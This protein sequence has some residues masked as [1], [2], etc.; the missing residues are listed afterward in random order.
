MQFSRQLNELSSQS[1]CAGLWP[2][3]LTWYAIHTRSKCEKKVATQLD[4]KQINCFLPAV[5][6]M[7]FWS[8]RQKVIERPLFPGYVF[9]RIPGEDEPRIPVLRTNGVVGFVGSQ[10]RGTPIPDS[11]ME[12]IQTL[13]SSSIHFEPY[14]FLRVGQRVRVRGGYLDNIEGILVSKNSDRSLVI[15]VSLIQRSLAISVSGFDLEP[16]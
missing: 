13:L 16:I 8:D 12:N 2:E 1:A 7:R 5:K 3:P 6:E 14:P 10:G 4:N 11:E 9:V 15:S